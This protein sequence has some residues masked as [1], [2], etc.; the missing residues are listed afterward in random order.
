ME[1]RTDS[2][3]APETTAASDSAAAV[4]RADDGTD[5]A[6]TE[7]APETKDPKPAGRSGTVQIRVSTVIQT[8]LIA[9]L[10]IAVVVLAGFLWSAK[11][12]LA[13]RRTRDANDHKAEQ[14]ATDYAVGAATVN[15]QDVNSWIAKLKANTTDQLAGK[16]DQT[17]PQLQQILVPLKFT[18]TA[19]PITATVA[20]EQGG[21][22]KVNVFV[23]VNATNA[24][25][26]Q[27]TQSTATYNVTL[28]K[29]SG[30]KITDVGGVDG[31]LPLK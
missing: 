7:T 11:S 21:I 13:D 26:P 20:S 19:T 2:G 17:A 14:V 6:K 9:V 24:Q 1:E 12:D 8:A 30:W 23:N 15:Y 25:N 31:A 28:D 22:Y 4:D 29:N 27:G 3:D 18:S 10:G 5:T 16:F